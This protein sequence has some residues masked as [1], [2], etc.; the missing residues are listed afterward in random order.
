M[1][2]DSL[3]VRSCASAMLAVRM[4]PSQKLTLD[5]DTLLAMPFLLLIALA[6]FGLVFPYEFWKFFFSG[7]V[8]IRIVRNQYITFK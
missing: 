1:G 5:T 7:S 3:H 2:P 6:I 8:K 4:A